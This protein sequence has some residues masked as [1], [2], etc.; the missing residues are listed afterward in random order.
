MATNIYLDRLQIL[1][2][3]M[4]QCETKVGAIE[5]TLSTVSDDAAA[6]KAVIVGTTKT[7]Q[8]VKR[9]GPR[10]FAFALGIAV[11]NGWLSTDVFTHIHKALEIVQ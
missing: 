2:N 6:I 7:M 1:E 8:F 10:I 5:A 11:S 4:I 9:H 3:R